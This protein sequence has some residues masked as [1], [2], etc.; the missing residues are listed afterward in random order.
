VAGVRYSLHLIRAISLP[1]G[2]AESGYCRVRATASFERVRIRSQKVVRRLGWRTAKEFGEAGDSKSA[3]K[4]TSMAIP[5][6]VMVGVIPKCRHERASCHDADRRGGVE[7]EG[8][9]RVDARAEVVGTATETRVPIGMFVHAPPK[10]MKNVMIIIITSAAT[11]GTWGSKAVEPP[12]TIS[13]TITLDTTR[14]TFSTATIATAPTMIPTQGGLEPT[15]ETRPAC[16]SSPWRMSA[17]AA[18]G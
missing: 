17:E 2:A 16:L 9:D 13:A 15:K 6:K 18:W 1:R 8:D 14:G 7:R 11:P 12:T 4:R 5:R 10:P 3:G